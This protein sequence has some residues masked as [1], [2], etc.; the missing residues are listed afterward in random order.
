MNVLSWNCNM[1]FSTKYHLIEQYEADIIIIQEC[2]KLPIDF[3]AGKQLYWMGRNEAKGLAVIV[4]GD[5]SRPLDN[6]NSNLIYFLP[7]QTQYG[8]S[9]GTW[10]FNRRAKKF[11]PICS[12][13]FVDALEFYLSSIS[14]N[15]QAIIAGDFNNGPR[16][17]LKYFHK[18]NFRHI[19]SELNKKEYTSVYHFIT[20]EGLGAENTC[21]F[22]HQRNKKKGFFID[23]IYSKGFET[24]NCEVGTFDNW[25][26]YSD[27]VPVIAE[28][29]D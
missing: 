29:R 16:W 17:D 23:Y 2:E 13:N 9:I 3:I 11:G 27:H 5:S 1:S 15:S 18:N 24:V 25:N 20:N 19:N 7:I 21:T 12:G 14:S 8:L 6:I 10:A 26:I 28:F 22:F 4:K